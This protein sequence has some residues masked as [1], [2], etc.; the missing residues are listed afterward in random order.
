MITKVF[1]LCVVVYLGKLALWKLVFS[2]LRKNAFRH[3]H[4]DSFVPIH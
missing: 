3:H 2:L 1:D 4:M